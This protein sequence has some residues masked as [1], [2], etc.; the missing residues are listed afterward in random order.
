LRVVPETRHNNTRDIRL[1][2]WVPL[3]LDA[4]QGKQTSSELTP[5]VDDGSNVEFRSGTSA[6]E[7]N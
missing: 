5:R 3:S 7:L 4:R 6:D 2:N 1:L